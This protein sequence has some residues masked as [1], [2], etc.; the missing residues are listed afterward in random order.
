MSKNN[1]P[2]IRPDRTGSLHELTRK[3][4]EYLSPHNADEL[5]H[6]GDAQCY[7]QLPESL[8]NH[9]DYYKGY[10]E[11]WKCEE[12]IGQ[13]AYNCLISASEEGCKEPE[14]APNGQRC[15][16]GNQRESQ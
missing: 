9:C 16:C 13:A 10:K 8:T 6:C 7:N 2:I 15:G 4:A 11:G 1:A 5:G 12:G 3:D 14:G